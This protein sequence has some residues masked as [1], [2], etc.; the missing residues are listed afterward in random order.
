MVWIPEGSFIQGAVLQDK[1]AMS[2]EKPSHSVYLNGFFMD[3]TEVT[4]AQFSKFIEDTGYITL[5]ERVVDWEIIKSQLPEGTLKPHDSILQ[6]G[7]L[8][9][10]KS[11]SSVPN[12]Y[13]FSQWWQ[14]THE[15]DWKHPKGKNSS[16]EGKE[17]YP[18]VHISF[19]DAKAYCLWAGKRLPTEAEWEY[20]ARANNKNTIYFWGNDISQ[21]SANA[22]SWEGEF[23][24]SNTKEDGFER[25]AP[26]KSYLANGFGLYDIAG[27]MWEWTSNLVF[28]W[29]AFLFSLEK[30]GMP[31]CFRVFFFYKI[32]TYSFKKAPYRYSKILLGTSILLI[33][34]Y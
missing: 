10:K 22:N 32:P 24:V 2:H 8:L 13:D 21:L 12:L 16:I 28:Q 26:V 11:K 30:I 20:A 1:M 18:V 23:P 29:K 14:W 27:N 17:N 33:L 25:G 5:A 4:N 6:P 15:V 7:S 34:K 31:F 19:E 9:F 3:I